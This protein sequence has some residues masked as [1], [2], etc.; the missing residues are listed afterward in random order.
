V[1]SPDYNLIILIAG[2]ALLL[3]LGIGLGILL[4]RR[5]SPAALK[6]REAERK[7]DQLLQDKQAYEDEVVEHFTDTAKLLNQL[8]HQYRDVHNHL[9][10]G[11]DRLC[12]GRGPVALG[13]LGATADDSELPPELAD[14]RPPLDYAPKASPDAKGMLAEEFGIER[15]KPA[16]A[17]PEPEPKS[18]PEQDITPP[19]P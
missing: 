11:A 12:H 18:K 3:L 7:L 14:V 13:Q 15:G 6:Q 9:A 17:A 19:K 10:R 1:E 16:A 8:T 5:T 4:G 2:G